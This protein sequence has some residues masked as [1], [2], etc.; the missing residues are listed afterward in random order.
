MLIHRCWVLW[1]FNKR[2]LVSLAVPAIVLNILWLATG[3]LAIAACAIGDSPNIQMMADR[4]AQGTGFSIAIFNSVLSLMTGGRVWWMSRATSEQTIAPRYKAIIAAILESGL[5]YPTTLVAA[6]VSTLTM[7]QSQVG[8]FEPFDPSV[9][10]FLLAGL[11]PTLI[12]VRVACDSPVETAHQPG[13]TIHFAEREPQPTID[14]QVPQTIIDIRPHT[15]CESLEAD[16]HGVGPE[17]E[18][19]DESRV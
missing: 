18:K 3:I 13:L 2:V 4:I 19:T 6:K 9:I 1:H 17:N 14:S 15:R 12:I 7:A 10:A 5:L 16:M 8:I 11:A